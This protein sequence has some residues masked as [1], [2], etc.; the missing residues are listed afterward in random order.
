VLRRPLLIIGFW[1][2]VIAADVA[3][4]ALRGI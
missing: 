4:L 1:A 3:W 2:A